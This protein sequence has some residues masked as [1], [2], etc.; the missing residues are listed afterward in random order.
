MKLKKGSLPTFLVLFLGDHLY[1]F[2]LDQL[3]TRNEVVRYAATLLLV[4]KINKR[5]CAIITAKKVHGIWLDHDK[6]PQLVYRAAD[7]IVVLL[8]E[9]MEKRKRKTRYDVD[10]LNATEYLTNLQQIFDISK[11][12]PG[13]IN[14]TVNHGE[15]MEINLDSEISS[16]PPNN[17][18]VIERR[19]LEQIPG[20]SNT[21]VSVLMED[22]DQT[23]P[24]SRP[25]ILPVAAGE[26]RSILNEDNYFSLRNCSKQKQPVPKYIS[27]NRHKFKPKKRTCLVLDRIGISHEYASMLYSTILA[28]EFDCD[29]SQVV[30]STSTIYRLRKK[31]REEESLSIHR[32]FDP[33]TMKIIHWDGKAYS[34]RGGVRDKRLAVAVSNSKEA[35]LLDVVD[36]ID[37]SSQTTKDN[38]MHLMRAWSFE[39]KVVGMCFDTENVNSGKFRGVS[40]LLEKELKRPLLYLA[41][42]HHILEIVMAEVFACTI[43][44]NAHINGPKI[45]FFETFSSTYYDPAANFR[46]EQYH[47]CHGDYFFDVLTADEKI[48]LKTFCENTL[49]ISQPR[50]DYAELLKLCLL[51]ISPVGSIAYKIQAPGAYNRARFMC[52]AIYT[53][54]IYL[55]RHQL[56]LSDDKLDAV[57]Q[58]I[59][60][61][62]KAYIKY[63]FQTTDAIKSTNNDLNM[64]KDINSLNEIMPAVAKPALG[65]LKRHLW[66]LSEKLVALSFFDE[67]V[68]VDTKIKMVKNLR[69]CEKYQNDINR[70]TITDDADINNLYLWDFVSKRT[71]IFFKILK[72]NTAFLRMHPWRW[73]KIALYINAKKVVE[74]LTVVND[75]AERSIALFQSFKDKVTTNDQRKR[76]LQVVENQRGKFGKL[77]K[78]DIFRALHN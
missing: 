46:K 40:V 4:N 35:K 49:N 63:W 14:G 70:P 68:S 47:S 38:V 59:L 19:A 34:K 15:L 16:I 32:N 17:I 44:Q 54:K 8:S 12:K 60:F 33:N 9:Y 71:N 28:D 56:D 1:E 13:P 78:R 65:K 42:R 50:S 41:C 11:S 48:N 75:A 5:E 23:C 77:R 76:L 3:P 18:A 37:G 73:G 10:G 31:H 45:P 25:N 74:D 7:K 61:V 26:N 36:V 55:Y 53:I 20:S 62:I 29:E 43:E 69:K 30:C 39:N 52:R 22:S 72:I 51:L 27:R 58:L 64:L 66:Y 67:S 24:V 21:N 2:G 57:R 6:D